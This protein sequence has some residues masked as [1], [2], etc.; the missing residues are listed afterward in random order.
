[1][2]R[3]SFF[4]E[5]E[6]NK[7]ESMI[8]IVITVILYSIFGAVI[9]F[10]FSNDPD[11]AIA[12]LIIFGTVAIFLAWN[13]YNNSESII[14]NSMNLIPADKKRYRRLYDLVEGLTIAADIPMPKLY[15]INS[16]NI[17]AFAAGKDPQHAIIGVT[18]GAL[19]R[20]DRDELEGVL[21]HE[22]SH[23]KNRDT[24]LMTIVATFV[25]IAM[26]VLNILFRVRARDRKDKAATIFLA[27]LASAIT[28]LFLKLLQ[29]AISRKREYLADSTA[30][31]FNRNPDALADALEKIKKYNENETE[32]STAYEHMFFAPINV[33]GLFSTHPPIEKRIEKLRSM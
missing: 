12:S 14:V 6:K 30:V 11:I 13:S 1:M 28:I 27:I 2:K 15:I 9:G 29:Y 19:E 8:L 22:I 24:L 18:K 33:R 7:I 17:N 5:I 16:P 32:V 3:I 10:L 31:S 26:I 4:D 23:I 25:G 20:L 21:A